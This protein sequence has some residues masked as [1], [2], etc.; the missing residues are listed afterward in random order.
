MIQGE[1]DSDE[2]CR[3]PGYPESLYYPLPNIGFL[4]LLPEI[5]HAK[6]HARRGK[7]QVQRGQ[8]VQFQGGHAGLFRPAEAVPDHRRACLEPAGLET[9]L[10]CICQ[11][12]WRDV[13]RIR[14]AAGQQPL[15]RSASHFPALLDK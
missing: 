12:Q 13:G 15:R 5:R 8:Q 10:Q 1:T 4:A 3:G 9:G 6:K 14:Y 11:R 7:Q 2:D